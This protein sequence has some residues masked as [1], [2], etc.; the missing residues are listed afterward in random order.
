M[1]IRRQ[2]GEG[3]G[4]A[5]PR[6]DGEA[7]EPVSRGVHDGDEEREE[8]DEDEDDERGEARVGERPLDD[9]HP[10]AT[11]NGHGDPAEVL[12]RARKQIAALVGREPESTSRVE[13]V[14]GG[15][16]L[17]FE[18]VEVPRIPPTTD[19]MAS[20]SVAVDESG[21]VLE[22]GRTQRY[23]RNRAEGEA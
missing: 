19:V 15:W 2:L 17:A 11:P 21:N 8:D 23:S 18:V 6:A 3:D 13:H 9:P 10:I 16:R 5:D 1:R 20:Y 14:D 4:A 7:D 22:F 12:A